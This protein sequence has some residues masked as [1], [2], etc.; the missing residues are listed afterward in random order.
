[1]PIGPSRSAALTATATATTATRLNRPQMPARFGAC[2]QLI[3]F[4]RRLDSG[5]E[6]RDFADIG[7]RLDRLPDQ[8][9]AAIG[10][11]HEDIATLRVGCAPWP[12]TAEASDPPIAKLES[13]SHPSR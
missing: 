11:S 8:A 5:L 9:F 12:R 6:G 13:R 2:A 1:M 10:L 7:G 3:G 4:A